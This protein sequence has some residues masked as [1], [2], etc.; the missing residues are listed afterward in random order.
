MPN[1]SEETTRELPSVPPM[2]AVPRQAPHPRNQAPRPRSTGPGRGVRRAAA[3]L[4]VA[5]AAP[6]GFAGAVLLPGRGQAT[7]AAAPS[8]RPT[9]TDPLDPDGPGTLRAGDSGPDV[10]ALQERLL[11]IPDVYRDGSASGHYDAVLKAAVARFQLWYGVSGDETG[12]YGDDTR[13]ALE[14]RTAPGG[15]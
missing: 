6:A 11:R 14:S 13:G 12:V 10:T 15:G 3:A 4:A 8:L 5:T 9:G 1:S 2:P 7:T